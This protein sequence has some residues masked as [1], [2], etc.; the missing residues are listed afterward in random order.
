MLKSRRLS[1]APGRG[2][3]DVGPHLDQVVDRVGQPVLGARVLP[4]LVG[5]RVGRHRDRGRARGEV[6]P[7][8][9]AVLSGGLIRS[10]ELIASFGRAVGGTRA[11][12]S[13]VGE[14]LSTVQSR[15]WIRSSTRGLNDARLRSK[16]AQKERSR[17]LYIHPTVTRGPTPARSG[18]VRAAD[19][20]SMQARL[21]RVR[22]GLEADPGS[23]PQAIALCR[24]SRVV[25]LLAVERLAVDSLQ[26]PWPISR[27]TPRRPPD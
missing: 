7:Q 11:P 26:I 20:P 17:L 23:A 19:Q 10:S 8:S 6:G 12:P 21:E 15:R 25:R 22:D 1:T 4:A 9:R 24:R 16:T 5:T 3:F 13:L 27:R 18:L 14:G 2:A